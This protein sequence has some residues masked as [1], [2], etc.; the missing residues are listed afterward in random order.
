MQYAMGQ[1]GPQGYGAGPQMSLGGY[2]GNRTYIN[3]PIQYQSID[4]YFTT[5]PAVNTSFP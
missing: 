2:N 4:T 5:R 1:Y 3:N